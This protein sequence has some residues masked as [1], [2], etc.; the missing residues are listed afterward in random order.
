MQKEREVRQALHSGHYVYSTA[1]IATSHRWPEAVAG[2]KADFV[3]IDSEHT[4]L[5]RESLAW[6]CRAYVAAGIPPVVRIASPDAYEAAKVL[7][8]GASGFIAPYVETAKQVRSLATAARYRPLKGDRAAA[9][10]R[11][12]NTLE[13]QLREYLETRNAGTIFIANIESVPAIEN[14]DDILSVRGL[15]AVLI[16][17]HD[18]SCSLGIPEQYD[19]AKF[20]E[21]V[22]TIF[23]K[24][25]AHNVGAG[26]HVFWSNINQQIDWCRNAGGNLI[27]QGA[28]LRFFQSGLTA[29]LD[30]IREALGDATSAP[31]EP[32]EMV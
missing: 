11:N 21:A 29:E 23:H 10:V 28:D 8:G 27:M 9:A 3:F 12:P 1:V 15:D 19:H 17:P 25:R 2:A 16:G 22:R 18:L 6:I 7:D 26:I 13:P 5:S 30:Q 14:L 20:N 31:A 4:P 24:A 32:Q